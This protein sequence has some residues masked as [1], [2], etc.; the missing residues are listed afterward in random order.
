M[1][2]VGFTQLFSL[3]LP[4][5]YH[6]LDILTSLYDQA[7]SSNRHQSEFHIGSDMDSSRHTST[8]HS[9]VLAFD[10][11]PQSGSRGESF[12]SSADFLNNDV[13][14]PG[15]QQE[16]QQQQQHYDN[17]MVDGGGAWSSS[18][19]Q[20]MYQICAYETIDPTLLGGDADAELDGEIDGVGMEAGSDDQ[21][22]Q[23]EADVRLSNNESESSSKDS[24]ISS[25]P[26]RI[27]KP[28]KKKQVEETVSY[29]RK[30]P[31]RNHI[32][33]VIP[34]MLS[35]DSDA[36]FI[37]LRVGQVRVIFAL[38]DDLRRLAWKRSRAPTSTFLCFYQLENGSSPIF[39]N[40]SSFFIMDN[41]H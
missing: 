28:F 2:N 8:T 10:S 38:P 9:H 34:D 21:V 13:G 37:G 12:F 41:F 39:N 7:A 32:K 14:F 16:P 27:K 36:C 30:L 1:R 19:V 18:L 35:H 24:S 31:P 33:H 4:S 6:P 26:P 17:T 11:Q 25:A 23:K 29:E 20:P 40:L 3:H 15:D 5:T 22:R